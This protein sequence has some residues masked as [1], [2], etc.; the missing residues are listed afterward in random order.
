MADDVL[1]LRPQP[2]PRPAS[3][4]PPTRRGFRGNSRKQP[5][6]PRPSHGRCSSPTSHASPLPPVA[7]LSLR[8]AGQGLRGRSPAGSSVTCSSSDSGFSA[9]TD[10][11]AVDSDSIASLSPCNTSVASSS[12]G[13]LESVAPHNLQQQ[14]V[15]A[16]QRSPSPTPSLHMLPALSVTGCSCGS[17]S[18]GGDSS[19]SCD[20]THI[21]YRSAAR[22]TAAGRKTANPHVR[23]GRNLLPSQQLRHGAALLQRP[24]RAR[25]GPKGVI[26]DYLRAQGAKLRRKQQ[27]SGGAIRLHPRQHRGHHPQRCPSTESSSSGVSLRSDDTVVQQML[28]FDHH[29]GASAIQPAMTIEIKPIAHPSPSRGMA[30]MATLPPARGRGAAQAPT[31]N[32]ATFPHIATIEPAGGSAS[33]CRD[34]PSLEAVNCKQATRQAA[35]VCPGAAGATSPGASL[36]QRARHLLAPLSRS[37]RNLRPMLRLHR[38]PARPQTSAHKLAKGN[39]P[40]A[41]TLR[42]SCQSDPGTD[43]QSTTNWPD[44]DNVA[45]Q[46]G[47]HSC[48]GLGRWHVGEDDEEQMCDARLDSLGRVKSSS[49]ASESDDGGRKR[50][51]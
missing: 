7:A 44:G 24:V 3:G 29:V 41:R 11:H 5:H 16:R 51:D 49:S 17:W 43:R 1:S 28:N 50:S 45:L 25:T 48:D 23:N 2:P 6:N 36:R 12:G 38:R 15:A 8:L 34:G 32:D 4:V 42:V 39:V 35:P 27:I 18:S 10:D 14:F 47:R 21:R 13:S 19:D 9:T 40:S 26:D 46:Q 33:R 37:L 30:H 22:T 31:R 20:L